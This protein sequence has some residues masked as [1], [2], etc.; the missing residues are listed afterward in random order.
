V[1]L[2]IRARLTLWYVAI[3]AVILAALGGFLL[4]R[5]RA[6]LLAGIDQSLDVRAAQIS[7][8]L[9]GQGDGEFQDVSDA[10]LTGLPRGE[11]AAQLMSA[12]GRVLETSG[13]QVASRPLI[14]RGQLDRAATGEQV[15][16]SLTLGAD[17]EPFRVLAIG[18]AAAGEGVIVVAT[19]L[20]EANG[21]VHR[22]L[23]LMLVA[24]PMALALAGI[25]GW[26]LARRA[27]LPVA[28]MTDEASRIGADRMG[29]RVDVPAGA[30]ELNR[31]ARTLNAMLDRVQRGVRDQQRF[32][33]DA[34]HEL[35]TPL[36]IMQAELDVSLRSSPLPSAARE[37]LLSAREEVSRM[38]R[39]V[40]NLLTLARIDEGELRLLRTQVELRQVAEA[41]ARDLRPLADARAVT[42]E[43]EGN[44]AAVSADHARL[45]QVVTNLV[46]NAVKYS[47]DGGT[48]TL[49]V[50]VVGVRVRFSITDHGL[51]I[52]ISEQRRIFDKF[53]RLDPNMNRGVGGTGLGLYIC[54]ELVR[55]MDGRIW[56]E[57]AGLGRGSTFAV[58]LPLAGDFTEHVL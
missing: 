44:G 9:Q 40:E 14:D 30:D 4:F 22:L 29:E 25:G 31:L 19:S 10:S 53:Y 26:F 37:A 41:A 42:V 8:G 32:V 56:V 23:V 27:L 47:P 43:V 57:S 16:A 12:S 18:H 51:G 24:G 21:S 46:D 3:L 54:R 45:E 36:A 20:D 28:R 5:L 49:A 58:E 13:D 38:A 6:D 17:R 52:P 1:S 7:L 55:R 39:V 34:S 48:V 15:R 11:S 35:R 33:A 50:Q 2:P